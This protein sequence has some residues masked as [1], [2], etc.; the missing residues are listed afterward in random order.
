MLPGHGAS[1][2][3]NERFAN[4]EINGEGHK[5]GSFT[6]ACDSAVSALRY[7]E[8]DVSFDLRDAACVVPDGTISG[9]RS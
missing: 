2:C 1:A 9:R 7:C 5:N 4:C 6:F 3:A 8:S